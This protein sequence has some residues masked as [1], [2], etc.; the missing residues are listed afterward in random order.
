[1]RAVLV[2]ML[3]CLVP[4]AAQAKPSRYVQSNEFD[5]DRYRN[6]RIAQPASASDVNRAMG[7][8]PMTGCAQSGQSRKAKY[9]YRKNSPA[10]HRQPRGRRAPSVTPGSADPLSMWGGATNE[11]ATA[12]NTIVGSRPAG[13]PHRFCACALSIRI[14]GRIVPTLNLA[15]NWPRVFPHAQPAPNMVAA[16]RGHAFQLL[17]HRAG[18]VWRVWDAN[19]GRG[20]IR[21]H[22]RSIA[23]YVIVNPHGGRLAEQS[24]HGRYASAR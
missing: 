24:T 15:A 1:M 20:R 19:S 23:G 10:A 17:A 3:F 8:S 5:G 7:C 14:F 12:A 16:R 21:I 13:C 9:L 22:D 18:N 6:T 2:A 11:F 4:I